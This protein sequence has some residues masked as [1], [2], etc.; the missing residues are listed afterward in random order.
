[1]RK[2]FLI[3]SLL[4]FSCDEENIGPGGEFMGFECNKP[5]YSSMPKH[6]SKDGNLS[7]L[8]ITSLK[9]LAKLTIINTAGMIPINV[10][11]K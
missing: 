9:P 5:S 11:I 3:L 6:D 1:M 10:P 8:Y 2:I 7:K 4:I